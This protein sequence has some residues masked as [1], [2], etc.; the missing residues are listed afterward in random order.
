MFISAG[1]AVLLPEG[2]SVV[3]KNG[4]PAV[5]PILGVVCGELEGLEVDDEF[6]D[7]FTML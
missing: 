6:A 2:W 1:E 4:F 5:A 3:R 7:L